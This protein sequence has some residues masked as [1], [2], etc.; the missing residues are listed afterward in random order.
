MIAAAQTEHG[1]PDFGLIVCDEAHR[2][3]GATFT[4]EDQSNFVKVHDNG[5]IRGRNRLYMTATPRIYGEGAKSKAKEVDAVLASMDD[6][7]L[8]GQVL[9]HHGFAQAVESGILTDYRVIVLVMDEGQVSS[10]VQRRLQDEDSQLILDDATKIVGCW[11]ALSK[12]RAC[13]GGGGRF[14]TDA[15]RAGL[16]PR[17]QEFEADPQRVRAGGR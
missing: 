4:G 16:L 11:K 15:P 1:L 9:S 2:T 17:H 6:E 13:A 8:F 7:A 10:S 12:I 14:R 3:T 5:V